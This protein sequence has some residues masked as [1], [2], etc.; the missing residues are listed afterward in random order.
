MD[1]T[2]SLL[3]SNRRFLYT[4]VSRAFAVEPDGAFLDVVSDGHTQEECALLDDEASNG[5]GMGA[6]MQREIAEAGVAVGIERLSSEYTKLFIG[7]AKLPAP[8][9]E[10]VY[11]TG[12]PLLFQE[13]TL[14][15]RNAYRSFGYSAV[16]YPHEADDHVAT[17]LSFMAALAEQAYTAYE[18][19]DFERCKIVLSA[20]I[21]F[22]KEHLLTWIDLFGKRLALC[23]QVS[24]FYPALAEMVALVCERDIGVLEELMASM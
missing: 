19:G 21:D 9:W 22:L 14:A 24:R 15:V 16:G 23:D 1:Q 13:C 12:E 17:E 4:Y 6:R 2:I 10:S 7:P 3:L 8:P 20:Q 18:T 11:A 5:Y